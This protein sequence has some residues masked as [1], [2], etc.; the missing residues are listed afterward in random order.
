MIR[1]ACAGSPGPPRR[2]PRLH[3]PPRARLDALCAGL[4]RRGPQPGRGRARLPRA[5]PAREPGRRLGR[6]SPTVRTSSRRGGLLV[7]MIVGLSI[8]AALLTTLATFVTSSVQWHRSIVVPG[9]GASRSRARSGRCS[10]KNW[11]RAPGRDWVV[12]SAGALD[13]RAF[14]GFGRVCPGLGGGGLTVAFRGERLPEPIR[15]SA[16]VLREDGEWTSA[17]LVSVASTSGPS[18][19]GIRARRVRASRRGATRSRVRGHPRSLLRAGELPPRGPRLPLPPWRRRPPTAHRGKDRIGKRVLGRGRRARSDARGS[20]ARLWG[21]PSCLCGAWANE[22]SHRDGIRTRARAPHRPP[23]HSG[24][25]RALDLRARPR[26]NGARRGPR[27]PWT[28]ERSGCRR[29]RS[30]RT[31]RGTEDIR[32]GRHRALGRVPARRSPPR[33][34][35]PLVLRGRVGARSRLGHGRAAPGSRGGGEPSDSRR[36]AA[37]RLRRPRG[38]PAR[39]PRPPSIGVP[40]EPLRETPPRSDFSECRSS[41]PCPART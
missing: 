20:L 14:R 25:L 3:R 5:R 9:G 22:A 17:P 10:K 35:R 15:D 4:V 7:E 2:G 28:R 32:A 18:A 12:D 38:R 26:G 6:G 30:P 40:T 23:P 37:R 13:L 16:L 27:G 21:R 31:T 1:G 11:G 8:G 19:C 29:A 24:S 39:R 33:G 41:S 34:P 36:G